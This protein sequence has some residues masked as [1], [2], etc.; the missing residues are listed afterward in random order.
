MCLYLTVTKQ[1]KKKTWWKSLSLIYTDSAI[2]VNTA[3]SWR[4]SWRETFHQVSPIKT[5]WSDG[6]GCESMTHIQWYVW[7]S[8]LLFQWK[9]L[10]LLNHSQTMT[11]K[12]W[13][14]NRVCLY[15]FKELFWIFLTHVFM[16]SGHLI[17]DYLSLSLTVIPKWGYWRGGMK[18]WR[19]MTLF[20]V[21]I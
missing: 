11:G 2:N 18:T 16:L 20:L 8:S 10:I 6:S 14:L 17:H 19:F 4:K 12:N 3:V 15:L 21:I 1:N 9:E 7:K 13:K 5:S